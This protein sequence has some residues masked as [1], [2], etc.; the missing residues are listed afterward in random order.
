MGIG[1]QQKSNE[2]DLSCLLQFTYQRYLNQWP[3]SVCLSQPNRYLLKSQRSS[4]GLCIPSNSASENATQISRPLRKQTSW[5]AQHSGSCYFTPRPLQVKTSYKSNQQDL[6]HIYDECTQGN[7]PVPSPL[8][9]RTSPLNKVECCNIVKPQVLHFRWAKS[10]I[11]FVQLQT[12]QKLLCFH[13]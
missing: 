9:V 1:M 11:N 12:A 3:N 6:V 5:I 4:H 8:K 10:S 13:P 2:A 7:I